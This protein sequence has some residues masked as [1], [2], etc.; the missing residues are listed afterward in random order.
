MS[1]KCSVKLKE[2]DSEKVFNTFLDSQRELLQNTVSQQLKN[3][4]HPYRVGSEID[5]EYVRTVLSQNSIILFG[6]CSSEYKHGIVAMCTIAIAHTLRGPVGHVHDFYVD[7]DHRGKGLG[8]EI[9]REVV[10]F[11]K[12]RGV[13]YVQAVSPADREQVSH[14]LLRAT[15]FQQERRE[16]V[17]TIRADRIFC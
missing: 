8:G 3:A 10:R 9:F 13:R 6:E 4:P 16:W 5:W 14:H 12:A 17:Y 2:L 11:A 7:S 1:C 15:G